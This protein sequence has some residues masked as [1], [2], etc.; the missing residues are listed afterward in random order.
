[1]RPFEI[2]TRHPLPCGDFRPPSRKGRFG[3]TEGVLPTSERNPSAV[4]EQPFRHA[5]A[6]LSFS[7]YAALLSVESHTGLTTATKARH[8]TA[9]SQRTWLCDAAH[10]ALASCK[11]V[12]VYPPLTTAFSTSATSLAHRSSLYIRSAKRRPRRPISRASSGWEETH[13]TALSQPSTS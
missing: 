3:G 10:S 8:R 1:M 7:D 12:G 13:L 2:P 5:N 6:A 4:Q 9:L 11:Q